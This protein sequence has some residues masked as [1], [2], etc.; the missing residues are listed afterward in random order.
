MEAEIG[1]MKNPWK[2]AKDQH[3]DL[4]QGHGARNCCRDR[5]EVIVREQFLLTSEEVCRVGSPNLNGWQRY[6]GIKDGNGKFP[7]YRWFSH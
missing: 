5:G 2:N 1:I 3:G 6:P 4:F 7:I